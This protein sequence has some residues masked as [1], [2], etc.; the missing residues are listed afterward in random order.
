MREK[1][2]F[3][4][5]TLLLGALNGALVSLVV[6]AVFRIRDHHAFWEYQ[7][8]LA[9]ADE[10]FQKTGMWFCPM[11][12][13]PQPNWFLIVSLNILFFIIASYLV[14]RL[15][16][17]ERRSIF[18]LWQFVGFIFMAEWGLFSIVMSVIDFSISESSTAWSWVWQWGTWIYVVA[19]VATNIIYGSI[20]HTLAALGIR[21]KPSLA[22]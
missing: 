13:R 22:M 5:Q 20:L 6:Y 9:E 15:L 16:N 18:T 17:P 12:I 3:S 2:K 7:N 11:D 14:H 10:I 8:A 1:R 19:V 21:S 4:W